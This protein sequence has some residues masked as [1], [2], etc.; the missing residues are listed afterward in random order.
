MKP[1]GLL[2]VTSTILRHEDIHVNI[3]PI[4]PFSLKSWTVYSRDN[5]YLTKAMILIVLSRSPSYNTNLQQT[6]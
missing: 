2:V 4:I 3:R 5:N 6:I 1:C